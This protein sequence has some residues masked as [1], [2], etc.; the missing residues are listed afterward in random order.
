MIQLEKKPHKAAAATLMCLSFAAA[1]LSLAL[2]VRIQPAAAVV[3][4]DSEEAEVW[5]VEDE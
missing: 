5:I 2:Y 4:P 1:L 3:S